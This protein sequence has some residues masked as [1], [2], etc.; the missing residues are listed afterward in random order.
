MEVWRG[1]VVDRQS[2]GEG[3]GGEGAGGDGGCGE[4][5][6][7]EGGGGAGGGDGGGGKGGGGEVGGGEGDGGGG[8]GGGGDRGGGEGASYASEA[9]AV[10]TVPK[11]VTPRSAERSEAVAVVSSLAAELAA[12]M[13]GMM[14]RAST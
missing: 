13:L 10:P 12:A 9:T 5:G 14:M 11:M 8:E 6:G 3:G 1:V 2:G 4:G 7:C